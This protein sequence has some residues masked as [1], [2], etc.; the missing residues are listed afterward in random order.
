MARRGS[1]E[2]SSGLARKRPVIDAGLF[3]SSLHVAGGHHLAAAHA[4][5]GTQVDDVIGAADGVFVVFD[6]HQRVAVPRELG[7]RVEQHAVVARMQADGGLVEHV[8]HALQVGAE[9]R[10]QADALRLAARQRRR[11]AVQR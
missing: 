1:A 7:Q 9:L 10:R 5:A 4:G 8:T 2:C 11:G 3:M 6:D